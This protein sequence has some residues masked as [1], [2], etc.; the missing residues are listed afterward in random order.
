MA[1]CV[2]QSITPMSWN[3]L[4]CRFHYILYPMAE[5]RAGPS[6]VLLQPSLKWH[7]DGR[8][9]SFILI[10]WHWWF[11]KPCK[12]RVGKRPDTFHRV[13]LIYLCLH[14]SYVHGVNFRIP[15]THIMICLYIFGMCPRINVVAKANGRT[16][17]FPRGHSRYVP[18]LTWE[19][20]Q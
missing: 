17:Q 11:F 19:F 18:L 13:F 5:L 10:D 4:S 1:N 6:L 16:P 7:M 2:S 12:V 14:V 15:S 3:P 8:A 9:P 20:P